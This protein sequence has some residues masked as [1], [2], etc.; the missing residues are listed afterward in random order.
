[1]RADPRDGDGRDDPVEV[2]VDVSGFDGHAGTC[3]RASIVVVLQCFSACSHRW[4]G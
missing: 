1:M 2:P 4:A 3:G